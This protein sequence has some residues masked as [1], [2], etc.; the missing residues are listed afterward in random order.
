MKISLIKKFEALKDP[1]IDRHKLYPLNEILLVALGTIL[2][3][4]ESYEDMR[5]FGLSKLQFLK[6]FMPFENGIP[7]ADTFERVLGLLNPKVFGECFMEWTNDLKEDFPEI[8]AIDGKT[9]RGSKKPSTG[10]RPLHMVNA[11][12]AHNRLV[13]GCEAVDEKSNEIDAIPKIL[14]LLT[15]KGTIVTL[16]AMGCQ[17][18]ITDQIVEKEGNYVIALKGNQGTLHRDVQDFFEL[19]AKTGFK[20]IKIEEYQT[21]DKGHG[22]LESRRYVLCNDID[23]LKE[24]H[25]EWPTLQG[26]GFVHST[27][28][29]KETVTEETRYFITSLKQGVASFAEAVRIHWT[30]ENSLHWVLDVS[31]HEDSS[32][33]RFKAA[34][35]NLAIIRR[36]ALNLIQQDPDKKNS[37]K[38][39][40]LMAAWSEDYLKSLLL[41]TF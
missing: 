27:R 5:V 12:A 26:I 39:K 34:S 9:L 2:T 4:G 6:S 40:K 17:K 36:A 7:S 20:E 29:H 24:R 14:E 1:R 35:H 28:E 18:A 33:I 15:L 37:K 38:G 10:L 21:L 31:F 30:I 16:D 3:G 25:P 11:W 23:W 22:R 19:E 8:I 13:L 41:Q 32:R